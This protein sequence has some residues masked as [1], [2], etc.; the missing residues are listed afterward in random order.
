MKR[1]ESAYHVKGKEK[2]EILQELLTH[3]ENYYMI[4]FT[5]KLL[6]KN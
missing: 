4:V 3:I 1:Q 5:M 2:K 6:I